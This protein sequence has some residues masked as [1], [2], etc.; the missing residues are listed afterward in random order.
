M[1]LFDATENSLAHI[2]GG[3]HC[4][5][6]TESSASSSNRGAR[7]RQLAAFAR[8]VAIMFNGKT[9]VSSRLV[10]FEAKRTNCQML[11]P[12][13]NLHPRSWRPQYSHHRSAANDYQWKQVSYIIFW[14]LVGKSFHIR[15]FCLVDNLVFCTPLIV[16][17]SYVCQYLVR[18]CQATKKLLII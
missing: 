11:L 3:I 6:L 8:C 15:N 1:D 13:Q 7:G 18:M 14:I 9:D 16:V 17:G 5:S 12:S 4:S 2:D 10:Q